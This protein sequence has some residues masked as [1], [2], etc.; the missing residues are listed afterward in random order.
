VRAVRKAGRVVCGGIHMTEIP[1]FPYDILWGERSL[2]SV[3]NLTRSDAEEFLA[4]AP[5][6]GVRTHI[7]TF[8][9][10]E[11]NTALARLRGGELTGAA[12]L[13]P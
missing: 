3:A 2:Q 9:L 11:A 5:R 12:V 4:L 6:A 7:E 10:A 13:I 1:A 8:P